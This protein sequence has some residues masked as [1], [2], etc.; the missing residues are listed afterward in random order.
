M[1]ANEIQRVK[2]FQAEISRLRRVY[3]DP[4]VVEVAIKDVLS[5]RF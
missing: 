3:A 5:R 4:A 1:V 2:E